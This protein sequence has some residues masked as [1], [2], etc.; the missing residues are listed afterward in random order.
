MKMRAVL[1]GGGVGGLAS[2]VALKRAGLNV[3]LIE[4][5]PVLTEIGAG[6]NLWPNAM[7]ALAALG[8]DKR[9]RKDGIHGTTVAHADLISG[10][11]L[12]VIDFRKAEPVY[13]DGLYNS[14]RADLLDAIAAE[15]Q[16]IEV[17]LG[18]RVTAVHD[19][20]DQVYVQLESGESH[21]GDL[22]VAADGIRSQVRQQLLG[23]DDF[24]DTHVS[25]WRALV[26]LSALA[27]LP[28]I[29]GVRTWFGP[30]RTLSAYRVRKGLL[31]LSAYVPSGEIPPESWLSAGDLSALKGSFQN[32]CAEVQYL[33]GMVENA[34]VTPVRF[35]NPIQT[36][37]AGRIA[38]LG[39]A[40]HPIPPFAGQGAGLALEDAVALASVLRDCARADVASALETYGRIRSPRAQQ[41][42]G[43]SRANFRDFRESDP[44]QAAARDGRLHGLRR[45]DP[46]RTAT[47]GWLYGYDPVARPVLLNSVPG[48]HTSPCS[49]PRTVPTAGGRSALRTR[50][51]G[52]RCPTRRT[53]LLNGRRSP[54]STS[55]RP[56]H[57]M[58]WFSCTCT[59]A[60]M[61]G[62]HPR[63]LLVLRADWRQ[64]RERGSWSRGIHWLRNM[65][66]PPRSPL[67]VTP[68]LPC[69]T[70]W[71]VGLRLS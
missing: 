30:G 5:A 10:T 16:G 53:P 50:A 37:S 20:G 70:S 48:S 26:P 43:L 27:E 15:L 46:L 24:Q 3:T 33:I 52:H 17:L 22:V 7:K 55:G 68:T 12:E 71:T 29:G 63:P 39:D 36:W 8:V 19:E 32:A 45:I 38:L 44:I 64:R 61:S 13:R 34:I 51:S 67:S 59:A 9:I 57:S 18:K 41:V 35:R 58:T 6:I 23:D 54:A 47:S 2:A 1:V 69:R 28:E 25:A 42:L 21:S 66:F 11:E 4:Q 14:H 65:P 60:G 62:G 31:S 56:L 49:L 40:A